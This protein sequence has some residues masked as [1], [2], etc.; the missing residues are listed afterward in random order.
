MASRLDELVQ[1]ADLDGL[2]RY[3]DDVCSSRDWEHLVTVRNDARAAVST[4]RQLWPIATL[5]NYR[6]A[7]WAPPREAA[8]ALDDTART[9]MPGPVSEILAVHHTWT[10]LEPFLDLGHDRSLFAYE[11]S[12]RGDYVDP[13]EFTALDVPFAPQQWEPQY[14]VA[15]YSDD[16]GSFPS[17]DIPRAS[18]TATPE[19]SS[20]I[21]DDESLDAFRQLVE[22]WTA[23]SNGRAEF[24]CVE[25]RRDNALH[26]LGVADARVHTLDH[27]NALQWLA[28]AGASGGA[29]GRRRG[30][31][32]GRFSAWWF[33]AH[34]A[35][36]ADEWPVHPG[37]FGTIVSSLR[38]WWWDTDEPRTGWECRLVIEDEDEGISCALSAHDAV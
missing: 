31:A 2:V 3:V 6:L 9:F 10:S 23:H 32:T 21:D 35:G 27:R 30:A 1:R 28:W 15:T 37:E 11:R 25:G 29:H 17:P 26:A 22:P 36:I 24:V 16:G 7:L 13:A 4:G 38:Y 8:R 34:V 14:C 33:L 19:P 20:R 5:A 12:L 18:E